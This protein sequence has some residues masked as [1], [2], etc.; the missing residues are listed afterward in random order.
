M[1]PKWKM[2]LLSHIHFVT[3]DVSQMGRAAH[4]TSHLISVM[5]SSRR[6]RFSG[7]FSDRSLLSWVGPALQN[8]FVDSMSRCLCSPVS[9][10]V[11]DPVSVR[12]GFPIPWPHVLE[13]EGVWGILTT[14]VQGSSIHPPLKYEHVPVL[15]RTRVEKRAALISFSRHSRQ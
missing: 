7:F 3:R 15:Q 6:Q 9:S 12:R 14:T 11:G 4:H 2:S 13:K 1:S 5:E 10:Q 8:W